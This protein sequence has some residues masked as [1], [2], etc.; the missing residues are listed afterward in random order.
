MRLILAEDSVLLAAGLE[1][2]LQAEGHE[3][4]VV[5][6][7]EA[8]VDL[9]PPGGPLPDLVLTDVRMPPS[10]TDEGLRAAVYL[11][12]IHPTLPILVLSQYVERTY[13]TE[14]FAGNARGLGYVLKDRVAD[15]DEFLDAVERV[16]SGGTVIDPEVVAQLLARAARP[17]TDP[18][19]D[20]ERDVL[21]LM[22]EGRSNRAIADRLFIGVA[23]V[24][25]HVTNIFLKLH[26]APA[27]DD[28]R[29]VL[30]VLRYLESG[31]QGS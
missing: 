3:T 10:F 31:A 1:R 22:A 17:V 19:S 8:L 29:R 15:V 25:K 2:L 6:T 11:R 14:L 28:H 30:A 20:R 7:A 13:A 18:L 9:L 12:R 26:L 27:A 4:V 21:A 23:G 16:R 24:E 5:G